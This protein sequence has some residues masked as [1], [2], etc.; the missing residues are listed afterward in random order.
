MSA[1]SFV[2]RGGVKL[3]AALDGFCLDVKDNIALDVGASTGGFTDCLLQRGVK[4]VYAV[5]VGYGQLAWTLRNHPHVVVLERTNIRHLSRDAIFD[6]ITLAVIDVSFIS[7]YLVF[8]VV[9]RLLE[10]GAMIVALVKPQFE[11]ERGLVMKGGIVK[12]AASQHVAVHRALG[13]GIKLGW[14]S[15]GVLPSPILGAKGNQEFLAAFE[16]S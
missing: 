16:K 15:L 11:L 13:W 7:L 5:D 6:K 9:D 8:P 14:T 3:A 4:R 12:D 10:S 1:A 2:S